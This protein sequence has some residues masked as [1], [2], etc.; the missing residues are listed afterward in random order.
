ML[1]RGVTFYVNEAGQLKDFREAGLHIPAE[2]GGA[3]WCSVSQLFKKASAFAEATCDRWYI[4]SAKHGLVHPDTV[5]ESYDVSLGINYRSTRPIH[6]WG[7][8][9]KD[10]LGAELTGLD[11]VTLVALAGEQYRAAVRGVPWTV[12]V[13]MQA[14]SIGQQLVVCLSIV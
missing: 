7:A 8:M 6:Q 4:L 10:Q 1:I 9:V 2:V 11:D 3:Q 5:L 12:E 13:P 14:L